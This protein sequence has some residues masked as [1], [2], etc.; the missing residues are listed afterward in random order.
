MPAAGQNM[1]FRTCRGQKSCLFLVGALLVTD[2]SRRT[3]PRPS[4]PASL[5]RGDLVVVEQT[6][7]DFFEGRVLSVESSTL[8]LQR[9]DSGEVIQVG[10]ADVY[11]LGVA[12][13]QAPPDSLGICELEPHRWQSCKVLRAEPN[14]FVV[15]D[16][17]RI[18]HHLEPSRILE[19]TGLSAMNIRRRF[20]ESGRR[21]AFEGAVSS[22][23]QPRRVTG[24]TVAPHRLVL[25]ERDGKWQG[26][27][28]VEVDD[29]RVTVRWDG[30]KELTDLPRSAV[31][32]QPPACGLPAHGDRALRRPGGFGAPWKPVL[33]VGVDGAEVTIEDIDR[34]RFVVDLRELCPL[35][36][37]RGANLPAAAPSSS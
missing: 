12:R 32:P 31:M 13:W 36:E 26:A 22:A 6:A 8:K 37:S 16:T 29:E 20:D 10:Q 33:V 34:K 30:Q 4:K 2:C 19:P 28:V 35:G 23:G 11:R 24:W 17:A 21:R 1:F 27:R 7:A 5:A 9:S 18:E 14:G 25:A 3:E 15:A